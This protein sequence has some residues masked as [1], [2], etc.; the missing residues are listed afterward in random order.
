MTDEI[1]NAPNQRTPR[2]GTC[3]R[4]WFNDPDFGGQR[5][6]NTGYVLQAVEGKAL[7]FDWLVLTEDG[8]TL[9]LDEEDVQ[10]R[11]FLHYPCEDCNKAKLFCHI[12]PEGPE[13]P[14]EEGGRWTCPEFVQVGFRV[15]P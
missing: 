10:Q 1:I 4:Y 6:L 15:I 13:G 9:G 3:I 12:K 11:Y 8:A 2:V 5:R 14:N 7:G